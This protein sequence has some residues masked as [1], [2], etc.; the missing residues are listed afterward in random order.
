[1]INFNYELDFKLDNESAYADWISKVIN[2]EI[3]SE[4]DINFIFCDDNYLL[5]INQQYLKHDTLTDIISFDYSIGN[6][7]HGDI[8]I[9]IER[10]RENAV[11]FSV[12]FENE[13]KRVMA[14]GVLHYCGYKDKTD[15]EEIVMRQKEEE[16][17]KMFH[18]K[19]N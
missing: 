11:D 5:E 14:H 8:F 16:K 15:E 13:I 10:V 6:E 2:S 1:M 19:Q 9:S 3:K 4:G 7:L 12:P 17:M 18:V